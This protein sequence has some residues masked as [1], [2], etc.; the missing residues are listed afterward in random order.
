[1]REWGC[2]YER[3]PGAALLFATDEQ[4]AQEFN[5]RQLIACCVIEGCLEI[6]RV[7]EGV[8]TQ[9][10]FDTQTYSVVTMLD[11]QGTLELA[12][13]FHVFDVQDLPKILATTFDGMDADIAIRDVCS[14]LSIPVEVSE[15][16][17]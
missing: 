13:Y 12:A 5:E 3:Y 10:C 16:I 6:V 9:Y 14:Q 17:Q 2:M 11:V 1:M 4:E 15:H 7:S 8:I